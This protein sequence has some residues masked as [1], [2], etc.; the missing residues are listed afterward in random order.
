MKRREPT[1][2]ENQGRNTYDNIRANVNIAGYH[3]LCDADVLQCMCVCVCERERE[4]ERGDER[5]RKRERGE[6]T[7]SVCVSLSV[8][9]CLSV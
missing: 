6:Q 8:S 2:H 5:E 3:T 1:L 7:D 9:V 4:R